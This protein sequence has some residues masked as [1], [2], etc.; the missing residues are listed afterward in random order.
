MFGFTTLVLSKVDVKAILGGRNPL[1]AEVIS[2]AP[3]GAV[4]PIPI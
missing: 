2:K 4:V 3:S 1:F